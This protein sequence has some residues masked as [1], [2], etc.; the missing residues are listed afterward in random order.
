[1]FQV[2]CSVHSDVT[3]QKQEPNLIQ[4]LCASLFLET[5]S[6][7]CWGYISWLVAALVQDDSLYHF[8]YPKNIFYSGKRVIFFRMSAAISSSV[9]GLVDWRLLTANCMSRLAGRRAARPSSWLCGTP[10]TIRWQRWQRWHSP[11]TGSVASLKRAD[12]L[13]A[14]APKPSSNQRF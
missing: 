3:G 1:M 13:F 11:K 6:F 5:A 2:C 4:N 12:I 14:V 8:S 9:Y 10:L 7:L